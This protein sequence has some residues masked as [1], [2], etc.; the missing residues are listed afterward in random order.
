MAKKNL[1]K[2][3][4]IAAAAITGTLSLTACEGQ[5]LLAPNPPNLNKL[6][7]FSASVSCDTGDF[8]ALFTRTAI[9]NWEITLTEPY[10]VEGITFSYNK[11]G[12]KANLEELSAN[13]SLSDFSGSPLTYIADSLEA[14]VQDGTASVVYGDSSF[15]VN[16]G[17]TV[18]YFEQ[19]SGV[20]NAFEIP[21]KR[22]KAEI[23]EFNITE[24]IFK[25]GADVVLVL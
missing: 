14:A 18:M 5:S 6:F 10:E 16:S 19:G 1:K 20:P 24:E 22:I 7:N 15:V 3:L 21:E 17:D 25:D 9:G 12:V 8:S 4:I 13:P 23:S 11:E 2:L